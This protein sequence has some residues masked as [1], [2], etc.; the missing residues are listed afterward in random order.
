MWLPLI[1]VMWVSSPDW[2][3]VPLPSKP[4]ETREK[5]YEALYKAQHNIMR[6]PEYRQGISSCVHFNMLDKI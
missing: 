5:C 4:Y 2:H 1:L 6:M 3:T